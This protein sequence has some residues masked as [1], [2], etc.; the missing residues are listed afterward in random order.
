MLKISHITRVPP[1][2]GI[3]LSA[4]VLSAWV[5]DFLH[6]TWQ[7]VTATMVLAIANA[8]GLWLCATRTGL[9]ERKDGLPY[10]LYLLTLT[11]MPS[12]HDCWQ[13]QVAVMVVMAVF[14]LQY[15]TYK[16]DNAAESA[17]LSTLLLCV[18]SALVPDL[19]WLI[20]LSWLAYLWLQSFSLRV[21]SAT[22]IAVLTFV[23]YLS[24]GLVREWFGNPYLELIA[25]QWLFQSLPTAQ[26]VA[27][28]VWIALGII[29]LVP[30]LMQMGYDSDRRRMG[31]LI[32]GTGLIWASVCLLWKM[33]SPKMLP[34]FAALFSALGL[35]YFRPKESTARAIMYAGY[36]VGAIVFW[37]L[38]SL[39]V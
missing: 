22:L 20:P 6:G 21:L 7:A 33:N 35:F 31:I 27:V 4:V 2:V 11:A 9:T 10:W 28:C 36:V 18:G 12:T 29:W 37:G 17:F 39:G 32:V 24:I 13:G 34:L 8:F 30:V 5:P 23:L 14:C 16:S 1:I 3:L 25:R 19:V 26:A 15:G 38:R